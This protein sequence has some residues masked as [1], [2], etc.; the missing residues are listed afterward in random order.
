MGDPFNLQFPNLA[1]NGT[2]DYS[3]NENEGYNLGSEYSNDPNRIQDAN[4][5]IYGESEESFQLQDN[6][7]QNEDS[8]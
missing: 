6:S 3:P 8:L 4:K 1:I 5:S 7:G 2:G